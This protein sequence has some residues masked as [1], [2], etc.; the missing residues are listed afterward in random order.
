MRRAISDHVDGATRAAT[1]AALKLLAHGGDFLADLG[2][3]LLVL[4]RPPVVGGG[5]GVVSRSCSD[6]MRRV[7]VAWSSETERWR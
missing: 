2:D 7:R 1:R 3:V 4:N 5:G 6:A